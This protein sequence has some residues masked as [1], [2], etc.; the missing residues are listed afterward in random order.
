M[1]DLIPP[2]TEPVPSSL[3][4]RRLLPEGCE[5]ACSH[6]GPSSPPS[7]DTHKGMG[8]ARNRGRN[9]CWFTK[10][11]RW[12][13]MQPRNAVFAVD[14]GWYFCQDHGSLPPPIPDASTFFA[15][16][17]KLAKCFGQ[18]R[19]GL[20][21]CEIHSPTQLPLPLHLNSRIPPYGP[22]AIVDGANRVGTSPHAAGVPESLLTRHVGSIR[23]VQYRPS[24]NALRVVPHQGRLSTIHAF[25]K[26]ERQPGRPGTYL[27]TPIYGRR[28]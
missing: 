16:S 12:S 26:V 6:S 20:L 17:W 11:R 13:R 5:S 23:L 22:P 19:H 4:S 3:T 24:I 10:I 15:R 18:G 7:R 27:Q 8:T 28:R 1:E 25:G 21:H 14:E 2:N 9:E